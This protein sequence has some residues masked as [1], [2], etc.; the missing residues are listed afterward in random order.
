MQDWVIAQK[1]EGKR[2]EVS[3]PAQGRTEFFE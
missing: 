1:K 3:S 2:E